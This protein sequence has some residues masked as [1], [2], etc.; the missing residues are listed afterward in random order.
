MASAAS[1][2]AGGERGVGERGVGER[3]FWFIRPPDGLTVL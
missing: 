3:G 1:A 2:G